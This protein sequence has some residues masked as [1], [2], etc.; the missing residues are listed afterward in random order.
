VRLSVLIPTRNRAELL[1]QAIDSALYATRFLKRGQYEILVS[2]N[3]SQDHTQDVVN[4]Y[5]GH[6]IGSR[7]KSNIGM[8]AN[9]NSL[10]KRA[11][12]QFVKLLSDDDVLL[13]TGI[14]RELMALEGNPRAAIAASGYHT[15]GALSGAT[16]RSTQVYRHSEKSL[17]LSSQAAYRAM[18]YKENI[19]GPPSAVM[20]RRN[21]LPKFSERYKYAVDWESWVYVIREDGGPSKSI[22]IPEPGCIYRVHPGNISKELM[23]GD[24]DLKEVLKLRQEALK[25]SNGGFWLQRYLNVVVAYRRLRRFARK[26]FKS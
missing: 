17:I 4:S 25:L 2:D 10:L 16:W 21:R 15:G 6:I 24:Q 7:H 20:F 14:M 5:E 19:Y 8:V 9:W 11:Q 13:E 12:G 3:D 22:F 26:V 18:V 23:A 1:N